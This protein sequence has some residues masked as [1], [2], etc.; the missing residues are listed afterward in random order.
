MIIILVL[1]S[2]LK[3]NLQFNLEQLE[4]VPGQSLVSFLSEASD[5]KL[6]NLMTA[7]T[8]SPK[9]IRMLLKSHYTNVPEGDI[10]EK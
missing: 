6:L 5:S 3:Q 10:S 4:E 2:F 1:F 9:I 7:I 8:N